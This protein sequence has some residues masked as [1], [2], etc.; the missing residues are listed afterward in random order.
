MNNPS[1]PRADGHPSDPWMRVPVLTA[2]EAYVG[3]LLWLDGRRAATAVRWLTAADFS[4]PAGA[5]VHRLAG[6][7][8]AS[9]VAPDPSAVLALGI[10]QEVVVG[11]ERIRV[12]AL[13][14]ARLYDHRATVPASVH[15]YAAAALDQRIR[16]RTEEMATRLLQVAGHAD[17]DE[18]ERLT[19]SEQAAVDAVRGRLR[20]LRAATSGVRAA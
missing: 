19:R 4:S 9:R 2:E 16:R 13:T 7:L 11:P 14:L 8:C 20:R 12:L 17:P 5:L 1:L 3:A 15:F 10:S 6:D 18:L